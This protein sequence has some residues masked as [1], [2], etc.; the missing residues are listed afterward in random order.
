[1]GPGSFTGLRVG[2]TFA[3]VF[4]WTVG[5]DVIALNTL[6]L[7]AE[8]VPA[9][10]TRVSIGL[11]AQRGEVIARTYERGADGLMAPVDEMQMLD[12]EDWVG[13]VPAGTFLSGPV[14]AQKAR[15]LPENLPTIPAEFWLPSVAQMGKMGFRLYQA[16][17]RDDIWSLLPIYSRPAAAEEKRMMKK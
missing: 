16:G 14:L 3:K 6:D 13:T 12:L 17:R 9:E 11:D 1:Q 8:A 15:F 5:A 7:L 2:I 10:F 4:A